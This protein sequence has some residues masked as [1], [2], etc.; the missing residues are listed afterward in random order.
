MTSPDDT[1]IGDHFILSTRDLFL[2]ANPEFLKRLIE[3]REEYE[4]LHGPTDPEKKYTSQLSYYE[5]RMMQ[6]FLGLPAFVSAYYE[7]LLRLCNAN[8]RLDEVP[9]GFIEIYVEM[10][11]RLPRAD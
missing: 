10:R 7:R 5:Q 1:M 3:F 2:E 11:G 8:G 6:D 4:L 9:D